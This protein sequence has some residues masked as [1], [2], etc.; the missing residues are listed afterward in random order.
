MPPPLPPKVENLIDDDIDWYERHL[1]AGCFQVPHFVAKYQSVIC[2]HPGGLDKQQEDFSNPVDNVLYRIAR[3]YRVAAPT[4]ADALPIAYVQA[5][6]KLLIGSGDIPDTFQPLVQ[7]RYSDVSLVPFVGMAELIEAGVGYWLSKRRTQKV[8]SRFAVDNKGWTANDVVAEIWRGID[9]VKHVSGRDGYHKFGA[10][11]SGNEPVVERLATGIATLDHAL[12]GGLAV[13]QMALVIAPQGAGKTVIA[14]QFAGEFAAGGHSGILI[15]TEETAAELQL[16][17]LAQRCDIPFTQLKDGFRREVL[18]SE[19]RAA[20]E[21]LIGRLKTRLII[22]DWQEGHAKSIVADL[23]N[24]LRSYVQREGHKPK[25][26]IFDWIGG[27]MGQ[28]STQQLNVYRHIFQATADELVRIARDES[29][30]VIALAQANVVQARNNPRIDSSCLAE[31]K[32]LGRGATLI[33]GI[34]AL[35]YSVAESEMG[36]TPTYRDK[37]YIFI[38]KARKGLSTSVPVRRNFIYQRFEAW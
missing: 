22:H 24:E 17:I 35:Q 4:A 7:Q 9:A 19:Q 8:V 27:G 2:V 36:S 5:A 21:N 12:H 13:G 34:S 1:L 32:S 29:I 28:L 11:L 6:V 37:Q 18:N 25:W 3:E 14:T 26:I 31:C 20:V 15:S 16:R 33:M 23:R 30:A 38:S 10:G